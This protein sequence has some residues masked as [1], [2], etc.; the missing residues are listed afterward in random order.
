MRESKPDYI[1]E[2]EARAVEVRERGETKLFVFPEAKDGKKEVGDRILVG[3]RMQGAVNALLPVIKELR[4]RGYE[5]SFLA[6]LPAENVLRSNFPELVEKDIGDPLLTVAVI[7]PS[8][9]LSGL[10][11]N[12]GPGIEFYLAAE[13]EG[14]ESLGI[15]H[16]PTVWVEDYW[17]I[18]VRGQNKHHVF[19]DVVCTFDKASRDLD[20]KTLENDQVASER[21]LVNRTEFIVTG[22]PAFDQLATETDIQTVNDKVRAQFGINKNTQVITYMSDMP[23]NDLE[24]LTYLV[25][26]LN[27]VKF[28]ERRPVFIARI[29]PAIYGNGPL[30]RHKKEYE[31][32]LAELKSCDIVDTMGKCSTDEVA[33]ATDVVI[34]AYSTEGVKAVYRGKLSLFMLLPGLGRDDLKRDSGMDNLPV[35]EDGSSVGV[36]DVKNLTGS[37]S[38]LLLDES[39]QEKL[40][41][42]QVKHRRLDGHNADRVVEV[43]EKKLS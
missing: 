21:G 36:F 18:S 37:L 19:P 39:V 20:I 2:A 27:E 38:G 40:R 25:K 30:S 10:S 11:I 32:I 7:K 23:P 26:S 34:S 22:S 43:I 42:A 3:A 33:K 14:D 41:S 31:R 6:D 16:I 5:I 17:G 4:L 15:Q 8:L 13:A 29:H 1:L 9:I 12:G 35:I 28:G 24:T